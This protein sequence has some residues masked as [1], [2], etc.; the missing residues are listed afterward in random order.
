M[1]SKKSIH[2]IPKR[3]AKIMVALMI[4]IPNGDSRAKN[5]VIASMKEEYQPE[6]TNKINSQEDN[7]FSI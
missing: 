1:V 5:E 6:S 2:R 3:S 7:I 4:K